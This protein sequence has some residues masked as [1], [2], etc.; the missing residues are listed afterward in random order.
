MN[1]R[2]QTGLSHKKMTAWN[3]MSPFFTAMAGVGIGILFGFI[4]GL[5]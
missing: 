2:S 3:I 1:S 5:I 4:L